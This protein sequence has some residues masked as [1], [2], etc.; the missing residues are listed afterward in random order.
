MRLGV[1]LK[2]ALN[3]QGPGGPDMPAAARVIEALAGAARDLADVIATPATGESLGARLGSDNSDGDQQ[4]KLDLVAEDIFREALR[5]A[6]V[7]PYLSE[8]T[9]G[10]LTL[11]PSGSLAV[12]IDPLDGSSNIEVNGVIGTIFSILPAP[13]SAKIDPGLAFTQTGRAQ[14][15]AGF[16]MYGPQTRLVL[17]MG[18]GVDVYALNRLEGAFQLM[19][20]GVRIPPG[21]AE[22][23][24]NASNR[25]YWREPVRRYIDDCCLGVEGPRGA[26]FNMRWN[27]SM[28]ADAY[29]VL[30]RGGL[31]LYPADSR[32]GYEHGRL[33]LLYEASPV[34][35][36]TEQAG[37]AATDGQN[38]ILDITPSRPHA[39]TPL[40][41]GAADE[42]DILRH[43]HLVP[44]APARDTRP[45]LGAAV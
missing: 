17:T 1:T 28:V 44:A 15:A 3:E 12:A 11:D 26:N 4:R 33:R 18:A 32:R 41:F 5:G 31:F 14:I 22:Y 43:H 45:R 21:V 23:A 37:G 40:I 27:G 20:S 25:R 7:G 24:I 10:P 8:E 39:R 34:A 29:R 30:T 16:F 38:S 13:K 35:F 19:E 2:D 42:A 36:L 6:G 9:E